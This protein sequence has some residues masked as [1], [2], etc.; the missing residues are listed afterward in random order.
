MEKSIVSIA[1]GDDPQR[2]VAEVLEKFGGIKNLIRPKSTVVIKPN[3]GHPA[4]PESSVNTSPEMV[5]AVIK[6]ARKADPKEIIL[7]EAAAIG[8]DTLECLEVSGILKAAEEAG[9]DKV[10]DIKSDKDLINLPIRD[11]RSD[12]H[13]MRL[14]RFL[15]EAEHIVNLPIFK[16]HCSMVFTCALKNMK[17]VV[18][19][20]VHYQMHQTNLAE[21]MMDLWSILRP[22]LNIADLI[23]PAE[24]FGPHTGMPV[25]YGFVMAA[26][27]PVALDATAC[28]AV[29]LPIEK[30]E[31]F[32]P[33]KARGIGNFAE[34]EIE[35][36]G[37]AIE[38][39]FK[40]MWLPYLE[41][42]EKYPEYHIDTEGACSSCMALVGLTIEKLKA[43]GQYDDNSDAKVYVGKKK[44]I[45]EDIPPDQLILVGDCLKR[46]KKKGIFVE[47]C[48]PGEPA[49]HW[50]IV[51]RVAPDFDL[52]NPEFAKLA[53]ERLGSEVFPF[54][55]HMMKIKA[56]WE[57]EQKNK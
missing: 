56:E 2:M 21:A 11:A 15:L 8:C 48:P 46:H 44:A 37:T 9:V 3:A 17:G 41:G 5:A 54:I 33:A 27:D 51:D 29:G 20:K 39:V 10:I 31:Y 32:E 24:G 36:R 43:F 53:R 19:D 1:K 25:E 16:S 6:E 7:A 49:P 40:P 18:Q 4:P 34:E 26:K 52:E 50:A 30:V 42:F 28:R 35:I 13:N 47:G 45:P 57:S 55:E 12:I 22:D 38:E 14:P 23:K